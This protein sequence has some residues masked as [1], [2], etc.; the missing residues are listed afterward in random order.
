MR[1]IDEGATIKRYRSEPEA[2]SDAPE[3]HA[4]KSDTTGLSNW[5]RAV[6]M[7][8]RRAALECR[9][10]SKDESIKADSV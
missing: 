4:A 10:P 9:A 2:T 5:M 3:N 1:G 8:M 7:S 6:H